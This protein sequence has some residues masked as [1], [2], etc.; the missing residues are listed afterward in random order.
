[1]SSDTAKSTAFYGGLFGWTAETAGPEY[2][3]YINHSKDGEQVAGLMQYQTGQGV[4]DVWSVYL[5]VEDAAATVQAARDSGAVVHVDAMP[6]GPLGVMAVISD[7]GGAFIGMW[8]PGEH[9]G[10]LVGTTGAPCHF[11][12]HTRDHD[13]SVAFYEKVFGWTTTP[14]SDTPELRYT[15]LE[16]GDGENAGIMDAGSFL[17]EGVPA[18]WSIYFAVDDIDAALAT[19]LELG[20]AV[21]QPAETT[22]Y[23]RLATAADS[24]G[25]LFKLRADA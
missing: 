9:R 3:G 22:P 18:H 2:G 5:A 11:E 24:T 12:L 7:V 4:A 21:V 15:L 13:A 6:V 17:P 8:Q 16:V 25:A 19:V 1:M 14:V 23:G 10:G 20:G